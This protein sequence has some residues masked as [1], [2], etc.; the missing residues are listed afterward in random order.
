MDN[1]YAK[2][3]LGSANQALREAR[4]DRT[5]ADYKDLWGCWVGVLSYFGYIFT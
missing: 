2:I 1:G 4:T 3:E 5:T